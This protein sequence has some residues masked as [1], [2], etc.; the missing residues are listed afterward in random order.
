MPPEKRL[1]AQERKMSIALA[2]MPIFAR[3]GFKGTTTREIAEAAQVSEALLYRH[4]SSKEAIYEEIHNLS[5]QKAA[6]QRAQLAELKPSTSSLVMCIYFI[7]SSILLGGEEDIE[8]HRTFCRL[9]L[10]S[11][12]EDGTFARLLIQAK[13]AR[14]LPKYEEFFEAAYQAGD[15]METPIPYANRVWFSHHL[16]AILILFQ[17]PETPIIDY[18]VVSKEELVKQATWF[19]LRGLGL[20]EEAILNYYNPE[21]FALFLQ[22]NTPISEI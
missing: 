20:K 18:G 6:H 14:W 2:A 5:C 16:A 19:A 13:M 1:C 3:K 8:T 4:F 17:L 7:I 22:N 10:Q 11:L 12:N 9:L 21:A 15:L